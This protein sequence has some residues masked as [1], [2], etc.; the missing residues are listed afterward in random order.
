MIHAQSRYHTQYWISL[1]DVGEPILRTPENNSLRGERVVK[2][3]KSSV[4]GC[5]N[6]NY[7]HL[8]AVGE[9]EKKNAKGYLFLIVTAVKSKMF[10]FN[11]EY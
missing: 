2:I 6:L 5:S 10:N 4:F 9:F 7:A 3:N 1:A 11:F 8:G